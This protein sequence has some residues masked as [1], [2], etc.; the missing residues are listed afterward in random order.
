MPCRTIVPEQT[1]Y[2]GVL[3]GAEMSTPSSG[4]H[5]PGGEAAPLGNGNVKPPLLAMGAG[6]TPD[7]GEPPEPL[8]P[9]PCESAAAAAWAAAWAASARFSC[10]WRPAT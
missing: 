9:L 5:V 10:C 1:A 4:D 2:S 6:A 3:P 8:L 7:D